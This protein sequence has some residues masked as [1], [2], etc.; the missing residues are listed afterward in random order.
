M[1]GGA[2]GSSRGLAGVFS[3]LFVTTGGRCRN[4]HCSKSAGLPV[5]VSDIAGNRDLVREEIDGYVFGPDNDADLA[6]RLEKLVEDAELRRRLGASGR[7]IIL[8]EFTL[9][10]RVKKMERLY[11]NLLERTGANCANGQAQAECRT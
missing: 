2:G 7:E 6:A 11:T 3:G 8:S 9:A 1:I 10:E 5:V 4:M